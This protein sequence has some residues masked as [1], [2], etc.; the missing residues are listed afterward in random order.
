MAAIK[1]TTSYPTSSTR[2]AFWL[3]LL[4]LVIIVVSWLLNSPEGLLGKADAVG[5]AICHRIDGRSFHI[6]NIQ[7][8]LCARCTG[9]YLG[10]V[11][12]VVTMAA[13]G[14]GRAGGMPPLRV[15][16]VL[17]AFIVIM[18]IDGVNSYLTLLPFLPHVYE[19]QNWLRL[20]TGMF[21]GVAV[22]GLVFPVFNQ[23]LWRNWEDRPAIASLRELGGLVLLA[24]ILIG[25]V[26][27][28]NPIILYPL[29]LISSAGVVMLLTI[30]CGMIFMISTRSDNQ[31]RNWRGAFVPLSAGLTLSFA[32]I[33]LIDVLRYTLTGTWGG[34]L[35]PGA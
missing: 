28:E 9:I 19:P 6:G 5:Y 4:A 33:L 10:V 27:T 31:A 3:V 35:I 24:A 26:L 18:G 25:L 17:V 14:R 32:V 20:T 11:L 8:P 7:M 2:P 34:F 30:T 29:A 1:P 12:G 16:A 22:S 15:I 23:T 21:N 13:A